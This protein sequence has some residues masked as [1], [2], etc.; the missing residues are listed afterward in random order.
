MICPHCGATLS[1][2]AR[3]CT[4]CGQTLAVAAAN[5]NDNVEDSTVLG[6][7]PHGTAAAPQPEAPA[8]VAAFPEPVPAP[9]AAAPAPRAGTRI[10]GAEQPAAEPA[11]PAVPNQSPH[12]KLLHSQSRRQK[13]QSPLRPEKFRRRTCCELQHLLRHFCCARAWC[14]RPRRTCPVTHG[15]P[16]APVE[17]GAPQ[18]FVPNPMF[19]ELFSARSLNPPQSA[20]PSA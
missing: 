6:T 11:F 9:Q 19:K 16:G 8:P 14:S 12:K 18:Q 15:A 13:S 10:P 7:A 20:L 1:S 5:S 4:Q 2:A 17:P 3:F